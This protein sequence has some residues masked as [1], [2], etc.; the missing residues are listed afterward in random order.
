MFYKGIIFT[1]LN[2][3]L[4]SC[5]YFPSNNSFSHRAKEKVTLKKIQKER[6]KQIAIPIWNRLWITYDKPV[7]KDCKPFGKLYRQ[8]KHQQRKG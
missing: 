3:T 6:K 5:S 2:K 8:Y 7:L 1:I 4:K